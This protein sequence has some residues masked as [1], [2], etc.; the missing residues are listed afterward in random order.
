MKILESLRMKSQLCITVYTEL[1]ILL[2]KMSC[3][4]FPMEFV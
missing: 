2:V 1:E 3:K 4:G